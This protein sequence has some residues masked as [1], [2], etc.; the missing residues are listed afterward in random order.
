M[1][2]PTVTD[3]QPMSFY[4]VSVAIL[5][6]PALGDITIYLR[7]A[8]L[9]HRAGAQVYFPSNAL[10]PAREYF[11]WLKVQLEED[12]ALVELALN[13][14]LVIACFEKYYCQKVALQLAA[15][16]LN[17][18]FV[19]AKKIPRNAGIQGRKVVVRGRHFSNASK[20]FCGNSGAGL[21]MVD[22]INAYA[23]NVF[24]IDVEKYGGHLLSK[25]DEKKADRLVLIFP[26]TPQSKKNYWL[27]G[28][29]LLGRAI[30][31]RG[32]RVEF[33]G[34][35]REQQVLEAALS[36][37]K[38]NSFANIKGLI[39]YVS[40]AS[41]VISNDS[42]GGHLASLMGL[43][44]FTITRRGEH[45]VWRPGFNQHNT[46]LYPRF[47]FK[48]LGRYVWR[49]FV[50]VWHIAAKLGSPVGSPPNQAM[51]VGRKE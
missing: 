30:R 38:V 16:L 34:M 46:V 15:G 20:A 29:K 19:S 40:T 24:S 47:R 32:W 11:P 39:D 12:A 8:W 1:M 51:H 44:T 26:T 4:G 33:V 23:S 2:G 50:P 41:V 9:M 22:W 48:L 42:G 10:H 25:P 35:P 45:F 3:N 31:R 37:F 7:L 13:Y 27:A 28:F 6:F 49:P 21:T 5:P 14:D 18:A 36:G 43:P 17:V